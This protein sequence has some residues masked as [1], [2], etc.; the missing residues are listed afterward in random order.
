MAGLGHE[1]LA[2]PKTIKL[3]IGGEFPRTESGRSYPVLRSG[4]K[5]VYANLCL[6][7]R[8]DFRAA[9]TAAQEALKGWESRTAYNRSQILYRMAEIIESRRSSFTEILTEVLGLSPA[10]AQAEVNGA[11]DA[12]VYYAGAADKYQQVVASVNP[13]NGPHHNFTTSEPVGI[14]AGLFDSED[15]FAKIVSQIAAVISSG[16]VIVALLPAEKGAFV[17]ELGEVFATSDLPKGVV[18][19]LSG[20]VEEL[21][22]QFGSHM[23][24]QS[25]FYSGS[26]QDAKAKLKELCV[27]NMKRFNIA[28]ASVASIE[29][30]LKYTEYKTIWHPV[31]Y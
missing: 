16:N 11:I 2:I 5:R 30:I 18:N 13:V 10:K 27:E 25:L 26:S 29:Q 3:F 17:A 7:S 31:E 12:F 1:G 19:L 21:L 8:K 20:S 28:D 6:A 22:E 14:V 4:S 24:V 23:E 9:V 15:N